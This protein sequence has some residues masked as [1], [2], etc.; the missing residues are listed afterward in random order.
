MDKT[1]TVRQL[2]EYIEA[3]TFKIQDRNKQIAN[4]EAKLNEKR[5]E[6]FEYCQSKNY[7]ANFYSRMT[8]LDDILNDNLKGDF[9][10]TRCLVSVISVLNNLATTRKYAAGNLKTRQV[11]IEAL[12]QYT[13]SGRVI[14]LGIRVIQEGE[15]EY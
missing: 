8:T 10:L 14:G 15:N 1:M 2:N 5:E 6:L 12:G 9:N 11:Y 7:D 13:K 3:C 4:L